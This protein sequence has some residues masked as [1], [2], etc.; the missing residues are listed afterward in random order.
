MPTSGKM[1]LKGLDEYIE[2]LAQAGKDIDQSAAKA[3][4]A[5]GNVVRDGMLEE[6]D[7]QDIYETGELRDHIQ[8]T[9]PVL[10]GNTTYIEI[11][12]FDGEHL[13]DADLARK[14][15]AQEYGYTRG[16]KSYPP[17]S[18][19]RAGADKRRKKALDTMKESLIEDG[20]L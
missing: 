3:L 2:N 14:A 4:T 19:I 1:D 7:R 12:V 6:I 15:N 5:G 10:D 8:V 11:G 17:R 20:M 18:Y 16:G 13:P 9:E